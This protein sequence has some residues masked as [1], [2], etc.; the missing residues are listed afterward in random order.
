MS[1]NKETEKRIDSLIG[2]WPNL[3][4]KKMFGGVCYLDGGNICFGIWQDYLIV[5]AGAE[6][7]AEKLREE[8]VRPFDATGRPM[9]GWFMV[10]EGGWRTD[11]ELHD[12][13]A[14]GREFALS[15]PPK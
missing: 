9:K 12:W 11:R 8:H 1:Y 15:L 3:E 14:I 2:D 13:L 7:A 4:K 5:R 6:T 10:A